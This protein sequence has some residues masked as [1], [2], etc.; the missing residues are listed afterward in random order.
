[1]SAWN[2][3]PW[4]VPPTVGVGLCVTQSVMYPTPARYRSG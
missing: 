4:D 2:G 3:R 1:M